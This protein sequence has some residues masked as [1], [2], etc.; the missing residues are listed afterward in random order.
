MTDMLKVV[1]K[2]SE[3][4]MG[5]PHHSALLTPEGLKCC[6]GFACLVAGLEPSQIKGICSPG[7]VIKNGHTWPKSLAELASPVS[8]GSG[9]YNTPVCYDLMI[10][11]DMGSID[12]AREA[13]IKVLGLKAGIAFEFED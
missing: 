8:P 9:D 13:R 3:W 5:D 2:R 11:N 4:I 10:A 12:D 6:L 7:G 1:V